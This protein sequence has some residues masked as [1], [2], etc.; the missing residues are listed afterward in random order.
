MSR[1]SFGPSEADASLQPKDAADPALSTCSSQIP[2]K[3]YESHV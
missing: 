3:I 1:I 2:L